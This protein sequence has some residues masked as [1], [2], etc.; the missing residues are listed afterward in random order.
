MS[1]CFQSCFASY[2]WWRLQRLCVYEFSFLCS[3]SWLQHW[4]STLQNAVLQGCWMCRAARFC[5]TV[6]GESEHLPPYP[7]LSCE[8]MLSLL[9]RETGWIAVSCHRKGQ[10]YWGK[11]RRSTR[12]CLLSQMNFREVRHS[13][14]SPKR[15]FVKSLTKSLP[16][17]KSPSGVPSLLLL[18]RM[19]NTRPSQ[20]QQCSRASPSQPR[21]P[22][23]PSGL[24]PGGPSVQQRGETLPAWGC[25]AG[26]AGCWCIGEVPVWCG[27]SWV[28]KQE[29]LQDTIV[30]VQPVGKLCLSG[31]T[32]WVPT[33]A[34]RVHRSP[35]SMALLINRHPGPLKLFIFVTATRCWAEVS[36]DL[37]AVLGTVRLREG[38]RESGWSRLFWR[39]CCRSVWLLYALQ[40][41]DPIAVIPE[42]VIDSLCRFVV[43]WVRA[44]RLVSCH[45]CGI[46]PSILPVPQFPLHDAGA[47]AVIFA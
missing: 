31:S 40:Q 9:R 21:L 36:A 42:V 39:L 25:L 17:G 1:K 16:C 22:P 41:G 10:R 28:G 4:N 3:Y 26:F 19:R 15:A 11:G 8:R 5:C 32:K 20:H 12:R 2:H 33:S 6:R 38:K 37:W 34:A 44:A 47:L 29:W 13:M 43:K 46:Q 14:F 35:T 27:G 45:G 23:S 30:P 7:L 18:L 24:W